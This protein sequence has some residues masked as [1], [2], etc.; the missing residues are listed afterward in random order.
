MV[1]MTA[2]VAY[3][4][5]FGMTERLRDALE[6]RKTAEHD[7]TA[8]RGQLILAEQRLATVLTEVR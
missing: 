6:A 5:R 2:L 1:D 8:A 4:Q 7:A 3:V